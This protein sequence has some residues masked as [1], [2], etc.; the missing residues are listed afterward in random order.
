MTN[1]TLG[2]ADSERVGSASRCHR[3]SRLG[4]ADSKRVDGASCCR[5]RGR[6]GDADSERVSG[7][8]RCRCHGQKNVTD[9]ILSLN[10]LFA[11]LRYL[12]NMSRR[13]IQ[14]LQDRLECLPLP[15]HDDTDEEN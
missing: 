13:L 8:Y 10:E 14:I 1:F 7:R 5:C 4:D 2:D 15:E 11:L 9:T 3:H 6:L 12:P